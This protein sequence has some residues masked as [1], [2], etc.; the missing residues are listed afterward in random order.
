M[1]V[2]RLMNVSAPVVGE[3]PLEPHLITRGEESGQRRTQA[4]ATTDWRGNR[5]IVLLAGWHP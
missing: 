3:R 5:P 2:D 1:G 4:A